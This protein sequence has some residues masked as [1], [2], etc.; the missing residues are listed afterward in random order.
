LT[1]GYRAHLIVAAALMALTRPY[2]G[3]H[4]PSDIVAGALV[5]TA[6]G[7]AAGRRLG[8]RA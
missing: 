6:V 2:L 4:Y 3:V 8:E 7:S 1:P 5:G